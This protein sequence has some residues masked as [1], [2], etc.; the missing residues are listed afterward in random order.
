MLS[1][2]QVKSNTRSKP[3]HW[4]EG[5]GGRGL[6]DHS[7][8]GNKSHQHVG[9]TGAAS[10]EQRWLIRAASMGVRRE[11]SPSAVL[12]LCDRFAV[13]SQSQGNVLLHLLGTRQDSEHKPYPASL[14]RGRL[15]L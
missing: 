3:H 15:L 2:D 11:L 12:C 13:D 9:H 8:H 4:A 5:D 1:K 6:G 7:L 10:G 14:A